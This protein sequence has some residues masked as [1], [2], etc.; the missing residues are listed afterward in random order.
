M[1]APLGPGLHPGIDHRRYHGEPC[2]IPA[3][4]QS[5]ARVLLE[6]SP[7]HAWQAHP[8]LGGLAAP[9]CDPTPQQ[10]RGT[11]I[12]ALLLGSGPTLRPIAAENYRGKAAQ[13]QRDEA[14]LLG[15]V[16]VLEAD[17]ADYQALVARLPPLPAPAERELTAVWHSY[18]GV[19]CRARLDLWHPGSLTIYDPKT[20]EDATR[21]ASGAS[22]VRDGRDIQAANNIEAV[23]TLRPELAGRVR[24]KWLFI[25]VDPP[26]ATI[27]AEPSGELLELGRRRWSRAV[28]KWGECLRA[29]EWPGYESPRRIEAPGWAL[30]QDLEQ[31]MRL[32]GVEP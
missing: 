1:G 24:F 5:I 20:C 27:E 31:E 2:E 28:A 7:L 25:E 4:T 17:L 3:L 12:H 10:E 16:P 14:R 18:D 22:I 21:A 26:F 8:A 32:Q 15:E 9:P 30:S 23:E 13:Q 29:D 6:R 11:A 19:L